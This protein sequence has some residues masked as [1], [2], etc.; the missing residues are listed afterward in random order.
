MAYHIMLCV[1]VQ[2]VKAFEPV[3]K[4]V[5]P[6]QPPADTPAA[7]ADGKSKRGAN[8]GGNRLVVRDDAATLKE[9]RGARAQA[10]GSPGDD[11]DE[12]RMIGVPWQHAVVIFQGLLKLSCVLLI[13]PSDCVALPSASPHYS[14]PSH[15]PP[16]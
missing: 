14:P 9:V 3:A 16:L 11:D 2:E 6:S 13:S 10:P 8:G 4:S 15:T 12:Q 7:A 1:C 5:G